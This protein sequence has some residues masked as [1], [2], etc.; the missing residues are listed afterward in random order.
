MRN[1][2]QIGDEV[3]FMDRANGVSCF[4]ISGISLHYSPSVGLPPFI[5]YKGA[6]SEHEFYEDEL[7]PSRRACLEHHI[8]KIS[9]DDCAAI[10]DG[11]VLEFLSQFTRTVPKDIG[12]EY[13]KGFH[14][15]LFTVKQFIHDKNQQEEDKVTE[16]G[17]PK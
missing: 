8:Q 10:K 3:W 6:S 9:V 5:G 14:F 7:F 1:K 2:Y 11:E 16:P 17:S 15:G 12:S 4:D 13:S